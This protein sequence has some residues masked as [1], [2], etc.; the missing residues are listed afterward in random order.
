MIRKIQPFVW[1]L[2]SPLTTQVLHEHNNK[3]V[4]SKA[5]C[6][7]HRLCEWSTHHQPPNACEEGHRTLSEMPQ[8]VSTKHFCF[9]GRKYADSTNYRRAP[10]VP[11]FF[12]AHHF[13]P[14]WKM[15]TFFS[16]SLPRLDKCHE[17]SLIFPRTEQT[18]KGARSF[19]VISWACFLGKMALLALRGCP[20]PLKKPSQS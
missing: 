16:S 12:C 1:V 4:W 17:T 18:F 19:G 11:G 20:Q 10:L 14:K 5:L 13:C 15:L 7:V 6:V 2:L 3:R 8:V 9:Y